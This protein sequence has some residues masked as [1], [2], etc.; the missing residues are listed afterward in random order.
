MEIPL[1]TAVMRCDRR[2][3]VYKLA[4]DRLHMLMWWCQAA[5]HHMLN[6]NEQ[7]K[8]AVAVVI[9]PR[10]HTLTHTCTCR[11]THSCTHSQENRHTRA[12]TPKKTHLA[13]SVVQMAILPPGETAPSGLWG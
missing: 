11:E 4:C 6:G 13:V 2:Q 1:E 5:S 3:Q 8:R 10:R 7:S 12:W 9:S